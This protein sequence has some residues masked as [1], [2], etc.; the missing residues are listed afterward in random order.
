MQNNNLSCR[1]N[2]NKIEKKNCFTGINSE[3]EILNDT[4]P[5]EDSLIFETI[6]TILEEEI[7]VKNI[8]TISQSIEESEFPQ[9]Q[10]DKLT[11][12]EKVQVDWS[13]E[14]YDICHRAKN[15]Y[16]FALFVCR[17]I[18]LLYKDNPNVNWNDF[19]TIRE[20]IM[21]DSSINN[22]TQKRQKLL[23]TFDK[24]KNIIKYKRYDKIGDT[25]S[26]LI[27]F[28]KFY[29]NVG[30]AQSSQ[31]I[32]RVLGRAWQTY[33][34]NLS[35]FYNGGLDNRPS[36]PYFKSKEGEFMMVYTIQ[37]IN[38]KAFLN[39]LE[40]TKRTTHYKKYSKTTAE[41]L[42]PYKHRHLQPIRIRYDILKNVREVRIIPKGVYYEIE[43]RYN[44]EVRDYG[45]CKD[46]AIA[47]DLG[48]RNP[49]AIVSNF[50]LQPLLLHG[51]ELKEA[52]YF[53][54]IKSPYYRSIQGVYRDILKKINKN[55]IKTVLQIIKEKSQK[56]F[57]D[58]QWKKDV[59]NIILNNLTLPY[60]RFKALYGE[61]KK[62]KRLF[63]YL[64]KLPNAKS[65]KEY[66]YYEEK[67]LKQKVV[68]CDNLENDLMGKLE[69]NHIQHIK[70]LQQENQKVLGDL[71]RTYHNKTRDAIHK[72]SRFVIN[73]CEDYDIGTIIIGYNEGWKTSSKLS[74]AVN[75]KFIPLPF[76][77]L[78]KA[79]EYKGIL[80]G[81]DVI[82][83]E[84]SYT[85]KCSALDKESIEFHRKYNGVRN[86]D[87]QGRDGMSHKHYGQF[88]SYLSGKYIHSDVNGA[89]NIGR[90]AMPFLF[91]NI[92]QRQML[93]PPQK[94]TVT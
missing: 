2:E 36:L 82:I 59:A 21:P 25:L 35:L 76:Y 28:S 41:L 73:V 50:G 61:N 85:S 4:G 24:L 69:Q 53:I 84:E 8:F 77:K 94:M 22:Y 12:T 32:N 57:K 51:K 88:Y 58:F 54:N 90:K 34:T 45:L 44:K 78:I 7:P 68:I 26:T 6:S 33:K 18:F 23:E 10:Q 20:N 62:L 27:K 13:P 11:L 63:N 66:L 30:Y 3:L 93:I 56:Y 40:A 79:I 83:Q 70:D 48:M 65:I 38:T 15:L 74:K 9:E 60:N 31:Q 42:F 89:L 37:N 49:L 86:P 71:F 52:N 87:I 72:I 46:N 43:I 29:E 17:K 19:L 55:K 64:K 67:E 14:L 5:D 39:H 47:I 16:N 91:E 75:R 81:I 80:C 92:P 1:K